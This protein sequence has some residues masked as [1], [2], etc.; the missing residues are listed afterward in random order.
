[1]STYSAWLAPRGPSPVAII[2]SHPQYTRLLHS[3]RSPCW[4]RFT[5]LAKVVARKNNAIL[6]LESR[7]GGC[8]GEPLFTDCRRR[9]RSDGEDA[10][11][12]PE[13]PDMQARRCG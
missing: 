4:R 10:K 6:I 12:G 13:P 7:P 3:S 2:G 5:V 9:V 8:W 1:M 11:A